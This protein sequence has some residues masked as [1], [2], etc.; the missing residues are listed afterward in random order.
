MQNQLYF[1][2]TIL[3]IAILFL[4]T[5]VST[6]QDAILVQIPSSNVQIKAAEAAGDSDMVKMFKRSD[7]QIKNALIKDFRT[8]FSFCPVYFFEIKDVEAVKAKKFKQVTF[9]DNNVIATDEPEKI[10]DYYIANISFYPKETVEVAD[11]NGTSV[12]EETG[13]EDHFGLGIILRNQA[14]EPV[15][16]K[17][18]FTSCRIGKRGSVFN[19]AKRY[20][21]FWGSNLFSRKLA[22]F[23]S[24]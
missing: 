13:V 14:Y 1:N 10:R 21:V 4:F 11:N 8:N 2:R 6:G 23:S 17:L 5:K 16:G 9:Y 15:K 12:R 20:Y 24:Q 22:K 18:R 7:S 19:K 3:V